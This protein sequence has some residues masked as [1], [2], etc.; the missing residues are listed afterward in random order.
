MSEELSIE[1]LLKVFDDWH[2]D[3][4]NLKGGMIRALLFKGKKEKALEVAEEFALRDQAYAQ[5]RKMIS[6]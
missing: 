3:E 1:K 2:E 4:C 5:I 6:E